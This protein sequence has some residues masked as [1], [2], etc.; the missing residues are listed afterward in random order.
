MLHV[1]IEG[2][3]QCRA[4]VDEADPCVSVAVHPA[5]VA[6][7]LSK[8]A[9]QVQVVPRQVRILASATQARSKAR[10]HLAQ[11]VP[12]RVGTV[13]ALRLQRL[14]L[15]L[16]LRTRATVRIESGLDGLHRSHTCESVLRSPSFCASRFR[17][18]DARPSPRASTMRMPGGWRGP[19]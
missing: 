8:P 9:L 12:D 18:S 11:V 2:Q 4:F 14:Q 17:W 6:W 3:Q 5:F 16:S 1:G 13:L 7:G 10:H 15:R 19:P